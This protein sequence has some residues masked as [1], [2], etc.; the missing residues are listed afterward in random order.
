MLYEVITES[1]IFDP[2]LFDGPATKQQW[3][4]E[5]NAHEPSLITRGIKEP[6]TKNK[7]DYFLPDEPAPEDCVSEAK[8]YLHN[9]SKS[10]LYDIERIRS[11]WLNFYNY[12]EK[13]NKNLPEKSYNF[14]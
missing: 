4:K 12:V 13:G 8:N 7:D 10:E 6:L 5:I 2:V 1:L 9:E 11:N 3:A 14:V